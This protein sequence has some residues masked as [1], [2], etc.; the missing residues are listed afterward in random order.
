MSRLEGMTHEQIS[1]TLGI[2][3]VTVA[4][5]IVKSLNFLKSY[6]EEHTGD[7]IL[8]IILLRGL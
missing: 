1:E 5:Y 7:T 3:K 4:Q 2:H 8:V 6:L